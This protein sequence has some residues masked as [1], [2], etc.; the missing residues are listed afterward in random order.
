M[1]IVEKK[2]T[3]SRPFRFTTK[4]TVRKKNSSAPFVTKYLFIV[5]CPTRLLRGG[6]ARGYACFVAPEFLYIRLN[7][8]VE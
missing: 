5:F 4:K 2:K 3:K 6:L 1:Q 7:Q 8:Q